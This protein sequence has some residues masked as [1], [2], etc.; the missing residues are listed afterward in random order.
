MSE[1]KYFRKASDDDVV[2]H[3]SVQRP[4]G[5]AKTAPERRGE[6]LAPP[7]CLRLILPN[8]HVFEVPTAREISIGRRSRPADPEVTVDLQEHGG[9]EGGVSRYH[10][11]IVTVKGLLYL[12]DLNSVNGTF[13]NGH[14]LMPIAS[15]PVKDGDVIT[16]G[17]LSLKVEYC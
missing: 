4:K 10:A 17:E 6:G 5:K 12:R 16:L 1:S 14:R 3:Y 13:L 7:A 11:M 8:G 2:T 9:L 15:Y